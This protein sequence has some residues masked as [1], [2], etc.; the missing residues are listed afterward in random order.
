ML[1]PVHRLPLREL[2]AALRERGDSPSGGVPDQPQQQEEQEE[3]RQGG[4]GAH[5]ADG[6]DAAGVCVH[7]HL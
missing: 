6:A 3:G 7:A 5:A 4:P 1:F 2:S